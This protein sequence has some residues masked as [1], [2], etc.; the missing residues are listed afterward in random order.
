MTRIGEPQRVVRGVP[1]P[2]KAPKVRPLP[3]REPVPVRR[4]EPKKEPARVGYLDGTSM[5]VE[6]I[7]Y[8][9]P[10]CGRP[11]EMEDGQLICPVHGVVWSD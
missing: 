2:Y 10:I 9:C 5:I 3:E 1:I 8:A 4:Q 11:A 7:P 6:E